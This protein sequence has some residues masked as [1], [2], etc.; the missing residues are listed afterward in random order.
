MEKDPDTFEPSYLTGI[1]YLSAVVDNSGRGR[2][3]SSGS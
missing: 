2:P 1:D 3:T